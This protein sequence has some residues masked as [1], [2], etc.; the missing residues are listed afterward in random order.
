MK[1]LIKLILI[2][3]LFLNCNS[4]EKSKLDLVPMALLGDIVN[5]SENNLNS[6]SFSRKVIQ[7]NF[8]ENVESL[9]KPQIG[10]EGISADINSLSV[11]SS[12]DILGS[13]ESNIQDK[14]ENVEVNL[15]LSIKFKNGLNPKNTNIENSF[16]YNEKG[17]SVFVRLVVDGKEI[18]LIPQIRLQ[19]T[20]SYT[21]VIGGVVDGEGNQIEDIKIHFTNSDLDYGL[22]WYGKNGVC[23]K[24]F[25]GIDNAF[26]NPAKKTVVFSHGWQAGSVVNSDAYGREN[27]RYEMFFWEENNFGG[28]KSHN[29]LQ[30]WTNHSWI[31]KNWNTGIVYWNQFGDEP[32]ASEGNFLGVRS[33]EAKIWSLNGPNGSRYRTLDSNGND[34]YKN[35]DGKLNF[36]GEEVQV[37]SIGELLSLYVKDALKQNTSG[38]IRLVGHSLGNQVATFLTNEMDKAGV[39]I[40]R[41]A[42]LDPA[43]TDGGK[44]YLPVITKADTE[45]RLNHNGHKALSSFDEGKNFSTGEIARKIIFNVMNRQWNNGF[46][47]EIYH[48]TILNASIPIMD[49]N[50][51]LRKEAADMNNAP[52]YYSATQI[53]QKHVV[54]RHHY[55]WS[56]EASAPKECT[57]FFWQRKLT[58]NISGSAA[59]PDTRIREM[60]LDEYYWVQVEG[61]YTP[62]PSDDWFERKRKL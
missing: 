38:N 44:N 43:W 18:Q 47:L 62:D 21:A 25:P 16:L 15:P 35:W 27:F 39:N 23:E 37:N 14:E 32:A 19:P 24:Y 5:Q 46:S 61:R 45:I 50:P 2:I 42:L 54:I 20:R 55:F 28:D 53:G 10:P 48:T 13:I 59:T 3:G 9:A 29:G 51:V 56:M 6:E 12:G 41:L 60:M 36:N 49:D 17:E 31:D 30:K 4:N 34:I 1:N 58:G 57:I 22:Y 40:K 52:W 26:Y 7:T 11:S 8:P 33:A